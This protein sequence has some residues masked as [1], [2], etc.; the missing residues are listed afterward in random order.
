MTQ[1]TNHHN[2]RMQSGQ[3]A[4]YA[5]ILTADAERYI[6]LEKSHEYL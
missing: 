3:N 5:R 6:K 4:R 1:K 2:K